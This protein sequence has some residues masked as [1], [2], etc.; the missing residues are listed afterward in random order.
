MG[1]LLAYRASCLAG[2][3]RPAQGVSMLR[4]PTHHEDRASAALA[5]IYPSAWNR[6]SADFAFWAFS[7]VRLLGILG[8]SETA[9]KGIHGAAEK[10]PG[11]V[12]SCEG[13]AECAQGVHRGRPQLASSVFD[14]SSHRSSALRYRDPLPRRWACQ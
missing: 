10:E 5:F 12:I 14:V 3:T 9:S 2:C 8:N 11:C 1:C 4:A 6:N 7:E 13:K